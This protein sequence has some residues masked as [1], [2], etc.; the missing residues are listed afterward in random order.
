MVVFM[1][2]TICSQRTAQP[3]K[4]Y[5]DFFAVR[6]PRKILHQVC[7]PVPVIINENACLEGQRGARGIDRDWL[8]RVR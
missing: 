1:M 5:L 3:V 8:G 7:G 4:S 6:F 2:Y